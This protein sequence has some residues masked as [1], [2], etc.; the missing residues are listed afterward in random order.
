MI[1]HKIHMA[2]VH[3]PTH[4]DNTYILLNPW[5]V[6]N[7]K[8]CCIIKN[9]GMQYLFWLYVYGFPY[10]DHIYHFWRITILYIYK[11]PLYCDQ[12]H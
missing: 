6:L 9:I 7:M 11:L 2:Y 10:S 3:Q 8:W 5:D 12:Y 1:Q 4:I